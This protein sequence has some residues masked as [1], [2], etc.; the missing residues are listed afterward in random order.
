MLIELV[1][2]HVHDIDYTFEVMFFANRQS[3]RNDR[4]F[5]NVVRAFERD[6][7]VC[8]LFIQLRDHHH[9]GQHELIGIIPNLFRLHFDTF[10]AINHHDAAIGDPASRP[11]V[12]NERRI[13][14]RVDQIDFRFF[15]FEVGER[16]VERN[17]TGD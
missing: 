10:D 8:M 17:L 13:S 16:G 2:F 3:E 6:T 11:R 14:G 9:A 4:S 5:E 12:R 15:V 7:N 1:R